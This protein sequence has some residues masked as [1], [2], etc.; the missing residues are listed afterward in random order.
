MS[1]HLNTLV[2][3][4][5]QHGIRDRLHNNT[6]AL[7]S[8]LTRVAK[9]TPAYLLGPPTRTPPPFHR[10]T[11]A[12]TTKA[13]LSSSRLHINSREE[14]S[15]S[16]SQERPAFKEECFFRQLDPE[17]SAP[18]EVYFRLVTP[19]DAAVK[20]PPV[21]VIHG[22]PGIPHDYLNP[23]ET[24]AVGEYARP[25]LFF[26]QVGC[27]MSSRP[28]MATY[29][30]GVEQAVKEVQFAHRELERRGLL[31]GSFDDQHGGG[32]HVYGQSWGGMLAYEWL[33]EGGK[34]LSM[35]LSNSPADVHTV[36]RDAT[37][38]IDEI[39]EIDD[40]TPWGLMHRFFKRHEC[41]EQ[42]NEHLVEAKKKGGAGWRGTGVLQGWN[43]MKRAQEKGFSLSDGSR[44]PVLLIGATKDFV[45]ED[46]LN[47]WR[48][49][50][51]EAE[52]NMIQDGT[53]MPWLE[54]ELKEE[55]FQVLSHFLASKDS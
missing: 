3:R 45:T 32:V 13:T 35:V 5:P 18:R 50:L 26:D 36:E 12:F 29:P 1:L 17:A 46:C 48:D 49:V 43:A 4:V 47:M 21:I 30:Y 33:L 54:P 6:L 52:L 28:A 41:S 16:S 38:M 8:P 51:P 20:R 55:Y 24:L 19:V 25:V 37:K 2:P 9:Q 27:G 15:T 11:A 39:E 44:L 7:Y 22:G 14:A 40:T 34:C 53:H 42:E 10:L 31:V 23:L